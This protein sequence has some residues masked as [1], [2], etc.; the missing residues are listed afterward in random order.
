MRI[1]VQDIFQRYGDEFC[2]Q[3]KLSKEQWKAFRAISECRTAKMGAHIDVCDECGH[4]RQSY[5]SCRNRHC[6]KCGTL[7]K[8]EWVAKQ[9][10][11]LLDC[12][13]F[14]VV[15]TVPS[16][17]YTLF[18]QN[19][20]TMYTLLFKAAS[21]TLLELCGDDKHLGATP[22]ITA[23][24]HTWGQTMS[25]HPHLHCIVTGGGLTWNPQA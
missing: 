15:F 22:G 5:N 20:Q 8:E 2:A 24:L 14:H 10:E 1:E 18:Y 23:V 17:L 3:Y 11:S 12:A 9:S 16:E 19:Q 6:P 4:E 7:A 25:Y 13:Y 21:K